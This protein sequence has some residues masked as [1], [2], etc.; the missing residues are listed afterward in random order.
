MYHWYS[1]RTVYCDFHT[2]LEG[3][4]CHSYRESADNIICHSL[5]ASSATQGNI[6]Q[7]PD[8]LGEF[9]PITN[10]RRVQR[11]LL[12]KPLGLSMVWAEAIVGPVSH[13]PPPSVQ[14]CF[15]LPSSSAVNLEGELN[16]PSKSLF[17]AIQTMGVQ[18]NNGKKKFW[19][20]ANTNIFYCNIIVR[21]DV[22]ENLH[23]LY[24]V[25][26]SLQHKIRN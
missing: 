19:S 4:T 11:P 13:S 3:S 18:E 1:K 5:E 16:S 23:L 2:L 6:I 21:F 17:S 20:W 22:G 9:T 25:S 14:C 15:I 7:G 24:C 12:H 8:L 10:P 26:Y